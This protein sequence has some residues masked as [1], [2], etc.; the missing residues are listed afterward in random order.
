MVEGTDYYDERVDFLIGLFLSGGIDSSTVEPGAPGR[1]R[2]GTAIKG[3][4]RCAR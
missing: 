3:K 1:S 2:L 4:W